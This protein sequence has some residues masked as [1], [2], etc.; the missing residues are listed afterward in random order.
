MEQE[1]KSIIFKG[2]SEGLVIVI[3][4]EYEFDRILGEVDRKVSN[5]ARFFKGAKIKVTYRGAALTSEEEEAVRSIIDEKSGALIESFS[6]DEEPKPDPLSSKPA[7]QNPSHARGFS[8]RVLMKET[9]NLCAA[10]SGAGQ[11]SSMT[12]ML[13]SSGTSI[14]AER[15][16]LPEM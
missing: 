5:A 11:E 9:A 13:L 4:E 15:S 10:P 6:K 16:L 3:P 2:N 12:A 7:Q 1:K 14:P 8:L